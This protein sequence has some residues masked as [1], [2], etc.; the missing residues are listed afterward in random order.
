MAQKT[1]LRVAGVVENMTSEV[2]GTGGGMRLA[3]EL[4]VPLLGEIPLDAALRESG[5]A[6]VPLVVSDPGC[7]AA[8]AIAG[9]A[10]TIDEHRVGGFTRTLPL[11][12]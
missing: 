12:S 3:T 11:V 8:Q 2:F 7:E 6:G 4:G 1:G 9:V 5:D 10:R